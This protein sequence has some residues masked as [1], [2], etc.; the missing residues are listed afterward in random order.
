MIAESW[1]LTRDLPEG[2]KTTGK[3][4]R[5]KCRTYIFQLHIKFRSIWITYFE[6]NYYCEASNTIYLICEC[7]SSEIKNYLVKAIKL[8]FRFDRWK[9]ETVPEYQSTLSTWRSYSRIKGGEAAGVGTE[10]KAV[11]VLLVAAIKLTVSI[12]YT[13]KSR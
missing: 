9:D 1:N 11:S 5:P 8:H 7:S 3:I 10:R 2:K 12:L 4:F 6:H 13:A